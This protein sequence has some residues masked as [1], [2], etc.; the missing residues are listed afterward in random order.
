MRIA[1]DIDSTLHHYWDRLSAAALRRFG[2]ELP[3]EEQFDWGITR[4]RPEQLT[5]C[6]DETHCNEAILAGRPYPGAVEA[7]NRWAA[8]GHFIHITSHRHERAHPATEQWLQQIGLRFDELYCS[9]DK[10]ARCREIGIE[11]LI[12]DSPYN[13][14]AALDHGIRVATIAHPWNQDVCDTEDV[15]SA[16]DW[17]ELERL[18]QPLLS[19]SDRRVA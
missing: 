13:L 1:I 8:D 17:A 9:F 18:L 16:A 6:I 7:V 5:C 10:V 12:D 4:L 14:Q 15:V 3:Y 11:L 2:I 19:G